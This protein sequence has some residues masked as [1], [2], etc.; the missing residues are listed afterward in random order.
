MP[1]GSITAKRWLDGDGAPDTITAPRLGTL[2]I[3]GDALHKLA[4][5]FAAGLVLSGLGET[6]YTKTLTTAIIRGSAAPA[7]WDVSGKVGA[8]TV[9]GAVG[10][11]GRPWQLLHATA[12]ASLNLGQVADAQVTVG[13]A[14]G[15]I[16]AKF[17]TDGAITATKIT[18][19]TTTGIA[20]TLTTLAVSG[21]FGAN[22]TLDNAASKTPLLAMTLAGWLDGA[23]IASNGP[24]GAFT[25]VGMHDSTIQAGTA[26]IA[27]VTV[28]GILNAPQYFFINS[29]ISAYTLGT[30]SIKAVQGDSS[31]EP[32]GIS[33]HTVAVYSR[34]GKRTL[35]LAGVQQFDPVGNYLVDLYA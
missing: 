34:D 32:F 17:W 7:L 31:S 2:S 6:I 5:D 33:G 22:V 1:I 35:N 26:K 19:I 8:V 9:G 13:G 14:I 15:T 3:T 23:M 16:R 20:K 25:M 4:G 18:S 12:L 27:G 10:A 30:I 21:D 24:L 11:A 29:S 28:K